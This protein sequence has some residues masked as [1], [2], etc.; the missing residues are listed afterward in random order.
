MILGP[1]QYTIPTQL[2]ILEQGNLPALPLANA[3]YFGQWHD[4]FRAHVED[5]IVVQTGGMVSTGVVAGLDETLLRWSGLYF[6]DLFAFHWNATG[7]AMNIYVDQT[8]PAALH[9]GF[10][11][12]FTYVVPS[13]TILNV[14]LRITARLVRVRWLYPNQNAQ[15]FAV[16][17]VLRAA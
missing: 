10:Q 7:L 9:L 16:S 11:Q 5:V 14:S 12:V 3:A 15:G 6:L 2:P 1:I 17:A 8:L 13:N 4:T